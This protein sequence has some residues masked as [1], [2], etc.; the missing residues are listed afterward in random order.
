MDDLTAPQCDLTI[1]CVEDEPMTREFLNRIISVT[2]PDRKVHTAENGR[3]GLESFRES[4]ADIVLTDIS[5]PVMDGIRMA[6]EIRLLKPDVCI[7]AMTAHGSLDLPRDEVDLFDRHLLKP[8][9]RKC[10]RKT[11]D[12]CIANITSERPEKG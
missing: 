11:V 8:I 12:E 9:S 10:L 3:A 2:Y 5:M 1:L 7:I 4:R 6:R